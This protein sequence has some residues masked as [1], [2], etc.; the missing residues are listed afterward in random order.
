M[1]ESTTSMNLHSPAVAV[2]L[3]LGLGMVAQFLANRFRFPAIVLLLL[4]GLV[5]GPISELLA[6]W[7]LLAPTETFGGLFLPGVSLSVGIILFEGGMS[8]RLHELRDH[9]HVVRAES[10][11]R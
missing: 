9:G 3:V 8:L 7:K 10:T 4:A 11:E 2:S 1:L 5:V 6:G